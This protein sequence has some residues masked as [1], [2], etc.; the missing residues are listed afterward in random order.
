MDIRIEFKP[1]VVS[2]YTAPRMQHGSIIAVWKNRSRQWRYGF[3]MR[4][5]WFGLAVRW[6]RVKPMDY[7]TM[8]LTVSPMR[9]HR[10]SDEPKPLP[11]DMPIVEPCPGDVP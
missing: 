7:Y 6:L 2:L 11:P 10:L 4:I 3:V 9:S 1:A 5:L 8:I